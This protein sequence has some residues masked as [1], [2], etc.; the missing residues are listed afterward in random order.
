MDKPPFAQ[1]FVGAV[2]A[3]VLAGLIVW[4]L[5]GRKPIQVEVTAASAAGTPARA[6]ETSSDVVLSR[7]SAPR[8]YGATETQKAN[9][10]DLT[11]DACLQAVINDPDHYTNVRSGPS[12][13]HEVVARVVDGEVFCVT[14][15]KGRW[16][17]MR[18]ASGV[19]G[20]IYHDRVR[21]IKPGQ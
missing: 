5:T 3:A 2:L 10:R 19:A 17:T 1:T 11:A 8:L 21:V 9:P 18:T 4:F 12:T 7:V 15:Q 20:Y 13:N 14:A 6:Q 16:W